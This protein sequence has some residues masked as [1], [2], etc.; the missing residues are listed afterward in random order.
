[1]VRG[2]IHARVLLDDPKR[3]RRYNEQRYRRPP[4]EMAELFKDMP[5]AIDN[6]REIARRCSLQLTLGKSVLPAEPVPGGMTTEAF[7]CAEA[8]RGLQRRLQQLAGTSTT[9]RI[10]RAEYE[11]RLEVELGVI[12]QMGFAGYFL[13]VAD[14]IRW[15]RENGVP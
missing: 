8:A 12:C 2:R 5:E 9:R 4:G 13:I 10:E 14:F 6:S 7:L 1:Q 15:A 11:K 3:P